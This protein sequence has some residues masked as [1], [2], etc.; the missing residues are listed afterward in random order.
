M[1]RIE[2]VHFS[3]NQKKILDGVSF[4]INQGEIVSLVGLSG[5]GKTTLFRLITALL[6]PNEGKIFINGS[7]QGGG[8]A[9]TYMQQ[10]DLLLPWRTVLDNLLLISELGKNK[11]PK[12]ETKEKALALLEKVGLDGCEMLYPHQLSGGMR[13][14]VALARALLQ[15]RPFL[16]L[17]EPFG[18]LDVII[19]EELY[20]LVQEIGASEKITILFVTH[21]FRDA[22]AL[23]N[24]IL[25]L[26]EKKI[27]DTFPLSAE[28]K[29]DPLQME[30]LIQAVRQKLMR[31]SKNSWKLI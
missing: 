24:R 2:N 18:F 17:D 12:R 13:Q 1:L 7:A 26:A 23:S 10:E 14:R 5:S 19:R 25:V 4:T 20:Q 15:N 11:S 3:Y 22:I 28:I 31:P 21:D 30:A 29:A 9:V 8:A 6:S 27:I 16:L